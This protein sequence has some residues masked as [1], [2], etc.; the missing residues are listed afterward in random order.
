VEGGSVATFLPKRRA[1]WV[2]PTV[3]V[4]SL[5]EPPLAR[6]SS[7][8]P[9]APAPACPC[10]CAVAAAAADDDDASRGSWVVDREREEGE[11]EGE[12][13]YLWEKKMSTLPPS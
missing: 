3:M 8:S 10:P 7:S 12:D 9:A 13:G 1:A 6:E 11:G 2:D 5:A 4:M